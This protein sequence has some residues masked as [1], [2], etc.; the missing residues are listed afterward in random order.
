VDASAYRNGCWSTGAGVGAG[1]CSGWCVEPACDA[2]SAVASTAQ[3]EHGSQQLQVNV[4]LSL[5]GSLQKP[6][7]QLRPGT[8]FVLS[9]LQPRTHQLSSLL[10]HRCCAAHKLA[11]QQQPPLPLWWSVPHHQTAPSSG[12]HMGLCQPLRQQCCAWTGSHERAPVPGLGQH[13]LW[14]LHTCTRS[15]HRRHYNHPSCTVPSATCR[16]ESCA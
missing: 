3:H 6:H 9:Q 7:R 8:F 4:Q 10:G 13:W 12:W 16:H 15:A 5:C 11:V 14:S 2:C 1:L